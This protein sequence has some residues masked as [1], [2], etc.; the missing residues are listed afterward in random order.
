M[1]IVIFMDDD[2]DRTLREARSDYFEANGFGKDGG[3]A[4]PWVDFKLG[5][6]PFPFPNTA[7]RV[8]AVRCHDLH[9]VLTGYGT[10]LRG[11][12]EISAWEIGAGC[13][14]FIAAWQLNLA[15][16]AGG[17]LFM[18]RRVL[19][20]FVRGRRSRSL[21]GLPLEPLLETSVGVARQEVGLDRADRARPAP[22][23]VAWLSAAVPFGLALGL[24]GLVL[25]LLLWPVALAALAVRRSGEK[26]DARAATQQR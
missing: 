7:A 6:V 9:H 11:E 3:Y 18:P 25:G 8:R 2:L 10:D 15:G 22:A 21:Y 20:A 1:T 17:V 5:P 13:R 16:L 24:V 14:G 4:E 23:D 19:R 12:L 26:S